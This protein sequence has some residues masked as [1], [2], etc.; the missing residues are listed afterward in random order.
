MPAR[1]L[2]PERAPAHAGTKR[3]A[4]PG[5]ARPQLRLVSRLDARAAAGAGHPRG[6]PSRRCARLT[7]ACLRQLDG[8]ARGSWG[9]RNVGPLHH[10][11]EGRTAQS[12]KG[13]WPGRTPDRRHATGGAGPERAELDPRELK[14]ASACRS[15]HSE[16][17]SG[18]RGVR[19]EWSRR[20]RIYATRRDDA[21]VVCRS[22]LPQ[23]AAHPVSRV[24]RRSNPGR[25]V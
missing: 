1:S 5:P 7:S 17:R 21:V 2:P 12:P 22:V 16:R 14:A 6:L 24:I 20:R 8:C 25:T 15:E 23:R 11:Y 13:S 10:L 18:S 4:R 3:D 9:L 19:A